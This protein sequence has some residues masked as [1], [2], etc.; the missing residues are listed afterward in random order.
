MGGQVRYGYIDAL[1]GYAILLVIFVHSSQ[2]IGGL[3]GYVYQIGDQGARGVQLFF[4][5]SAITLC[6]SYHRR[7]DGVG[8]FYIR[9][10][11]VLRRC[12]GLP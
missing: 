11:F 7:T 12:F 4:V 10:L 3:Q 1:R 2:M 5:A 6:M 8:A 9:R